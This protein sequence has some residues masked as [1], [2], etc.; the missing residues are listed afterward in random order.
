MTKRVGILG[1]MAMAAMAIFQ[2]T[3]ASAQDRD[4]WRRGYYAERDH[5]YDNWREREWRE[6]HAREEWREHHWRDR[7]A[8]VYVA[9]YRY[10]YVHPGVNFQVYYGR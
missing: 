7:Y 8:P 5:R 3:V 1:L 9:P 4:G 2:P 6:E 10:G